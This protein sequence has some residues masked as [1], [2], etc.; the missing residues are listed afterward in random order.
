MAHEGRETLASCDLADGARRW[1]RIGKVRRRA[2]PGIRISPSTISQ[3]ETPVGRVPLNE[4]GGT[5]WHPRN[6]C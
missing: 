1:E 5:E 6:S 4:L 3:T 2:P